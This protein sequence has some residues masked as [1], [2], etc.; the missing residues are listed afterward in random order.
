MKFVR[1]REIDVGAAVTWVSFVEGGH[2]AL[3]DATGRVTVLDP[4]SG[5]AQR[6][7]PPPEPEFYDADEED[8]VPA[9]DPLPV[10]LVTPDGRTAVVLYSL[11]ALVVDLPA[12]SVRHRLA[13]DEEYREYSEGEGEFVGLPWA[14]VLDP[15]RRR[16][17][18]LYA[19]PD[20][21][22]STIFW[23]LDSGGRAG[24]LQGEQLQGVVQV[25]GGRQ[26]I[27][28]DVD[29]NLARYDIE[30]QR[31]V[32]TIQP[33]P[34]TVRERLLRSV[35]DPDKELHWEAITTDMV[36]D[37]A[38]TRLLTLRRNGAVVV[39]ETAT[40][41]VLRKDYADTAG[42]W[43]TPDAGRLLAF[44]SAGDA[45]LLPEDA[46][47]A[48]V[49]V[50]SGDVRWRWEAVAPVTRCSFLP[51]AGLVLTVAEERRVQLW[52]EEQ[53]APVAEWTAEA[54]LVTW[55]LA[56]DGRFVIA[57]SDGRCVVL[58]LTTYQ[59]TRTIDSLHPPRAH[60]GLPV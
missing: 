32:Q 54:D 29:G 30:T 58:Q 25:E 24:A 28:A 1:H 53:D 5:S 60:D 22:I 38:G 43:S 37:V 14:G 16:V 31:L 2:V 8:T 50:A 21:R 51:A 35:A 40:G 41:T 9:G 6:S 49:D 48:L 56:A 39:V 47:I 4:D 19:H 42:A 20:D 23:G 59:A 18:I 27:V 26:W 10:P 17:A 34:N 44:S 11:G 13:R 33:A 45:F 3:G 46:D 15:A 52:R 57:Q 7:L 55:A 12:G 36:A